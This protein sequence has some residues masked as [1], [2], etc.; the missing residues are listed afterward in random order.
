MIKNY[1]LLFVLLMT[2][3]VGFSQDCYNCPIE[4]G[5]LQSGSL[6][7]EILGASDSSRLCGV[8]LNFIHAYVGDMIFTLTSPAG[9]EIILVGPSGFYEKTYGSDWDINFVSCVANAMP[10]PGHNHVYSNN[11]NWGNFSSYTGVYYPNSGCLED[12]NM[13]P[14]GIWTL[15]WVDVLANDT[16]SLLDFGLQFCDS[17]VV[18]DAC[19]S[20]GGQ[21]TPDTLNYCVATLPAT[22]DYE[23]DYGLGEF[24]ADSTYDYVFFIVQNG[25]ILDVSADLTLSGLG[26]GQYQICGFSYPK[27]KSGSL[28]SVGDTLSV[29]QASSLV[30]NECTDFS[31]NCMLVSITTNGPDVVVDSTIC[32][33]DCVNWYGVDYCDSGTYILADS[34]DGCY[35]H[36]VLNL[37]VESYDT[38]DVSV[39]MDTIL[40]NGAPLVLDTLQYGVVG[41]WSG[42]GIT[43]NF[44][45]PQG[46]T[47][48]ITLVFTPR[49]NG[50]CIA[51]VE[52][53]IFVLNTVSTLEF[54]D[55]SRN[56]NTYFENNE[57]ILFSDQSN[58]FLFSILDV[59]GKVLAK[60]DVAFPGKYTIDVDYLPQGM[61]WLSFACAKGVFTKKIV[62]Q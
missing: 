48:E 54:A 24:P 53:T 40:E 31:D 10:D 8:H 47:G 33:G 26:I 20:E 43:G 32:V 27:N 1:L 61:Y 50:D 22:P 6:K 19:L 46:L 16:G 44:F 34:S 15:S 36:N 45:F 60:N 37:N 49:S 14:N 17:L 2:Q 55:L 29:F 39:A 57:L 38:I 59:T 28:P 41:D 18:I 4:M 9:Q 35:Y 62:K 3:F 21:L 5:E 7:L 58:N 23:V 11:D 52:T 30:V 12:F 13:D 42:P 25:I 51:I 56:V